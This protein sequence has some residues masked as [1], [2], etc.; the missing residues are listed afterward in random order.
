VQSHPK[1]KKIKNKDEQEFEWLLCLAST[2]Q[3]SQSLKPTKAG[4]TKQTLEFPR[5]KNRKLLDGAR[6][7]A[8]D[9]TRKEM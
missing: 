3:A 6:R 1:S 7:K 2:F 9:V 4:A 5:T 8:I